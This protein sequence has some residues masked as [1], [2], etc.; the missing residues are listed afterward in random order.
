MGWIIYLCGV[1][2]LCAG[3]LFDYVLSVEQFKWRWHTYTCHRCLIKNIIQIDQSYIYDN[4]ELKTHMLNMKMDE[5]H[6]CIACILF[7]VYNQPYTW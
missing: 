3:S 7:S 2:W 6:T 1:F 5:R 4:H